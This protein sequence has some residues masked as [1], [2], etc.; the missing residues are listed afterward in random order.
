MS[1]TRVFSFLKVEKFIGMSTNVILEASK[2]TKKFPGVV[3]LNEVTMTL[4]DGEILAV[5][6]EN[7]AGKSTL[8]KILA[9]V[10]PLDS[11]IIKMRGE[12]VDLSSVADDDPSKSPEGEPFACPSSTDCCHLFCAMLESATFDATGSQAFCVSTPLVTPH[13][14]PSLAPQALSRCRTSADQ[15]RVQAKCHLSLCFEQA[16]C[17]L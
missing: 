16:L 7:G 8:M 4:N 9:G 14:E 5:I 1:V 2:V 10:Q 6:G 15:S 3:A 11:G 12:E 13:G 17:S